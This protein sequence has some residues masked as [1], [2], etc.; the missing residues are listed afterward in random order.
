MRARSLLIGTMSLCLVPTGD[1]AQAQDAVGATEVLPAI[2]VVAP[3]TA[4]KP[5]RN[6]TAARPT[7]NIRRVFVYPTA[8]TP[9]FGSGL[10]VDKVAASINAVG[11][12]QIARTGSLNI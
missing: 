7:R 4:A 12:G 10:D 5:V 8:P 11:A 6:R 3:R 9:T 2:E 1:Y